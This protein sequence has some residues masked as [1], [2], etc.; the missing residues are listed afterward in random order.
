MIQSAR[1]RKK[2]QKDMLGMLGIVLILG[3]G[4]FG[5]YFYDSNSNPLDANNCSIKNG[6]KPKIRYDKNITTLK[7]IIDLLN[8]NK[9]SFQEIN[10]FESD[11]E[12]IFLKLVKGQ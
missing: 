5:F 11:L 2:K 12:D 6:P 8:K 1:Q 4:G 7:K 10:T 9:I 3:L